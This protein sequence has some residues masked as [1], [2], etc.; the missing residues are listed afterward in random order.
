MYMVFPQ[1]S[2]T[3]LLILDWYLS[4]W[5]MIISSKVTGE[6]YN[7][8]TSRVNCKCTSF[9]GNLKGVIA[10]QEAKEILITFINAYHQKCLSI[11]AVIAILIALKYQTT[12]VCSWVQP[13]NNHSR[14]VHYYKL[15]QKHC[16][17]FTA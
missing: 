4:M 2:S 13:A 9:C 14:I 15:W 6:G 8:N 3:F 1:L 17:Q 10:P 7:P 12:L 16:T 5:C 11:S